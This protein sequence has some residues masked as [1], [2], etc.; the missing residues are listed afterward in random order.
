[1]GLCGV[2][3]G[4]GNCLINWS[5]NQFYLILFSI[6]MFFIFGVLVVILSIYLY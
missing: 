2:G 3:D 1:M 4:W 6:F 5:I